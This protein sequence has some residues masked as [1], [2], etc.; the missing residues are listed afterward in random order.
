MTAAILAGTGRF[1]F[2]IAGMYQEAL[3]TESED[4]GTELPS[5]YI[6]TESDA[7][8]IILE[9][10]T[11]E[12]IGLGIPEAAPSRR[13]HRFEPRWDCWESPP[14]KDVMVAV[15]APARWLP[16]RRPG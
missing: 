11:Q 15:V 4:T 10:G 14:V 1:I 2:A 3:P 12:W 13:A 7:V 16:W 5:F 9:H 6:Q 8:Q